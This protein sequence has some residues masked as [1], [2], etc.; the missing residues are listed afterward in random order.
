MLFECFRS[1]SRSFLILH[2]EFFSLPGFL[3]FPTD[4]QPSKQPQDERKIG[5][6]FIIIHYEINTVL[7]KSNANDYRRLS[8]FV[9]PIYHS[10]SWHLKSDKSPRSGSFPAISLTNDTSFRRYIA[11]RIYRRSCG[12]SSQ[13]IAS[14]KYLSGDLSLNQEWLIAL[15][16]SIYRLS[17]FSYKAKNAC[18][19]Y[20][21][22]AR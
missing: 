8:R 12:S 11:K 19:P 4:R 17:E 13:Y 10:I 5:L 1:H 15:Y 3:R 6:W 21:V 2:Q 20:L 16:R 22:Q 9:L 18:L 14:V 7:C